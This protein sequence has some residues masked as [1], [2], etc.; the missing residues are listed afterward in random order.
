M[1]VADLLADASPPLPLED[2]LRR[3][4]PRPVLL[5]AGSPTPES[6]AADA[7]E[8]LEGASVSVWRIADAPHV[9]GLSL[10]PAAYDRHVAGFLSGALG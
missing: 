8:R 1:G 3:I 5:V 10:H 9:S 2:C 7:Y 4:A 6:A